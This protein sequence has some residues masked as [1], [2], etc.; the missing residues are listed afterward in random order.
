MS[1]AEAAET[2]LLLLWLAAKAREQMRGEQNKTRSFMTM[3]DA[4]FTSRFF[5]R[6]SS[7]TRSSLCHQTKGQ[8][9]GAKNTFHPWFLPS[10]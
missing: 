10:D 6:P 8:P 4:F 2:G 1:E 3:Y 5:R 9:A 7:S